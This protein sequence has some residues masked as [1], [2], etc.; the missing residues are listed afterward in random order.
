MTAKEEAHL[1]R[2]MQED[3]LLDM[4]MSGGLYLEYEK[5]EK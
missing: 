5:F 1:Y 3:L 4:D 2:E